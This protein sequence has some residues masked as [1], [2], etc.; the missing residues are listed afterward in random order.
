VATQDAVTAFRVAYSASIFLT[1]TTHEITEL[2]RSVVAEDF[3]EHGR[4]TL[5]R[6]RLIDPVAYLQLVF[7]FVPREFILQR[8]QGLC[9]DY[10]A[11]SDEE[12]AKVL[13]EAMKRS[14]FEK[15]TQAAIEFAKKNG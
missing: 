15:M 7:K 11:L 1:V 6:V 13:E 5:S 9:I 4:A 14:K 2:A 8:E 3:A 10:G 12:F